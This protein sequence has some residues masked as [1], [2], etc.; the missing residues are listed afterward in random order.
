M[1]SDAKEPNRGTPAE[2][3]A[4]AEEMDA[5]FPDENPN[6]PREYHGR[7]TLLVALMVV[8]AVAAALW[9]GLRG[10]GS[11][12]IEG[13]LGVVNLPAYLNPEGRRVAVEIDALA[14]D[15]ELET[16][17]GA[18]FRLS[19][20]RGHPVVVNLWASWC[21]PCR[22][23]VPELIRLQERFREQGLIIVGVNIEESRADASGFAE[24]FGIN[25]P[26]PMDFSGA[27][28]R[29]YLRQGPP[30]TIFVNPEGRVETIFVGQA[31]DNDFER[32]VTAMVDALA[33]PV[34]PAILPGPKA[35][36]TDL[37]LE[38]PVGSAPREQAPDFVLRDFVLPDRGGALW[39][40]SAQRG[41][42]I[43]LAFVPPDCAVCGEPL[44][45]VVAAVGAAGAGLR[46]SVV[47]V[48]P[49]A[50]ASA[51]AAVDAA[52]GAE[53][54]TLRLQWRAD[55]ARLFDA[56][57]GLRFVLIDGDG[58]IHAATA[59]AAEIV[60]ALGSLPLESAAATT[61]ETATQP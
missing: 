8:G 33:A 58:I 47:V 12:R 17:N 36:P 35:L 52:D 49:E 18:R 4:G 25:Y 34:G 53:A 6:R 50:D 24:E 11:A 31:P 28:T 44:D 1:E 29:R 42:A 3:L 21:G 23:E 27:V 16:L 43:L 45:A 14:P 55:V 37:A 32:T 15:F 5:S 59:A 56:E 54:A 2:D 10:G 39:R 7:R 40:L 13:D 48:A 60:A 38:L 20:L 26:L 46:V 41:L 22:R 19:D 30:N 51:A 61:A 57:T 9:L